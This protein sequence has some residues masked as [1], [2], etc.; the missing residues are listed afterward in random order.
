ME[1]NGGGEGRR[2]RRRGG[3]SRG[4]E[5]SW[6]EKMCGMRRLRGMRRVWAVN[7]QSLRVMDVRTVGRTTA[8]ATMQRTRRQQQTLRFLAFL[9]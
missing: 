4:R 7:A 2:S 9:W 5:E 6:R 8:T 3:S 1:G